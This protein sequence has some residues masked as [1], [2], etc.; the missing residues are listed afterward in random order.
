VD[1]MNRGASRLLN[2]IIDHVGITHSRVIEWNKF[3][4]I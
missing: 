3:L 2:T 1:I 4:I